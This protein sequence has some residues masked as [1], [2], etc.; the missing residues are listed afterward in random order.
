M[1]S[2]ISIMIPSGPAMIPA[3]SIALRS[4]EMICV[5]LASQ[6]ACAT[7][8]VRARPTGLRPHCGTGT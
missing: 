6:P 4:L 2:R 5:V 3:V 7:V 1:A 8:S